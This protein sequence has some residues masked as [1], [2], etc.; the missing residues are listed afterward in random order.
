MTA[1]LSP[2]PVLQF[3]ASPGVPLV[4]GKLFT[5]KAGTSTKQATWTDS[6]QAVQNAN[7]IILNSLG[8]AAVWM[9]PTLT[10]KLVW[11]PAN[12]T[13]P[14]VSPL[15]SSD[16]IIPGAFG[17]VNFTSISYPQTAAEAAASV[18]PVNYYYQSV[19]LDTRRLND[20]GDGTDV[21]T[22]LTQAFSVP[23]LTNGF[24]TFQNKAVL[25]PGYHNITSGVSVTSGQVIEG[26]GV[27]NTKLEANYASSTGAPMLSTT[28]QDF[29]MSMLRV[30]G[31]N[32]ASGLLLSTAYWGVIDQCHFNSM[33]F[34]G[35]NGAYGVKMT[36]AACVLRSCSFNFY[37]NVADI[38]V[39]ANGGSMQTMTNCHFSTR[40]IGV[41]SSSTDLSGVRLDKCTFEAQY[42]AIRIFNGDS[43]WDI[44]GCY[45]EG[46]S[47]QTAADVIDVGTTNG[48]GGNTNPVNVNFER[49]QIA[50]SNV[51]DVTFNNAQ[52]LNFH[53]NEIGVNVSVLASTQ[54]LYATG[55]YFSSGKSLSDAAQ[56]STVESRNSRT[57]ASTPADACVV[58]TIDNTDKIVSSALNRAKSNWV[59]RVFDALNHVWRISGT[60]RVEIASSG[61]L[62]VN[63][64]TSAPTLSNNSDMVFTLTSNT[65]LRI[66]VRGS[67]GTTRTGNITLS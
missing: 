65:N 11:A 14:P 33:G 60:R 44:Q 64:K 10:Y 49:N 21:T 54:W 2:D 57:M 56:Y 23:A 12:D 42:P 43:L 40:S 37:N 41:T 28:G 52:Y 22:K 17:V 45:F 29:R 9:D 67:D 7:P 20:V 36:Q 39:I 25:M 38:A 15:G 27:A 19:P 53:N 35:T 66:S 26:Q 50:G 31:N 58:D 61:D 59:Q 16:N 48:V 8:Q 46:E 32:K 5:Y 30:E 51:N 1:I 6:T 47:G 34:S 18:T 13:D 24:G 4:G 55:N 63:L 3:W 62:L